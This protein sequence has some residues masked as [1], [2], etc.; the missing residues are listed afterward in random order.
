[1]ASTFPR[2][3][4]YIKDKRRIVG[5]LERHRIGG[6]IKTADGNTPGRYASHLVMGQFHRLASTE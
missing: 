2:T 3:Y 1:M 4:A 5:L 6:I